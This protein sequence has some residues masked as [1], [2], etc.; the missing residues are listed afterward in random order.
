MPGIRRLLVLLALCGAPPS[1][2]AFESAIEFLHDHPPF[3]ALIIA[4]GDSTLAEAYARGAGPDR[5]HNVKSVS[6]SV[7]AALVGIAYEK[8]DLE[9]LDAPVSSFFPEH[10]RVFEE[11]GK[12]QITLADLL[13]MRSGLETTSFFN[14]GRWVAQ[15][16]WVGWALRRPLTDPPGTRMW[17]STGNTHLISV[18]L[19]RA[20]GVPT[21]DFAQRRLFDPLDIDGVSWDRDPQGNDFGGNNMA[22]TPRQMARFGQLFLNDG[23]V[24]GKQVLP[25]GWV[26]TVWRPR[27]RSPWNGFSYGYLWWSRTIDGERVYFAWGHGG[28][29]IFVVPGL[30]LVVVTT[31]ALEGRERRRATRHTLDVLLTEHVFPPARARAAA[32]SAGTW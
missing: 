1:N 31:A 11:P 8:G 19:A 22:M 28:Q 25:E 18:I 20:T 12:T 29:R 15:D 17:Y 5:P 7:L 2:A 10:S 4:D 23:I 13:T 21:R 16:D 3:T 27:T 26:Q 14:Y 32:T 24:D 30:D 6:K 9:S